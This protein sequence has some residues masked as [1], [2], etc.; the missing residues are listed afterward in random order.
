MTPIKIAD[1]FDVEAL[2]RSLAYESAASIVE[3]ECVPAECGWFR[4]SDAD[5]AEANLDNFGLTT[6]L[7]YLE[8]LGLIERD[9]E[10]P[11]WIAIR[12]EGE[13]AR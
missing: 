5:I 8:A 9:P 12:D 1:G 3:S 13:A 11:D 7:I 2:G 10:H 6:A 4:C